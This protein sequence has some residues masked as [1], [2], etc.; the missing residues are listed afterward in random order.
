[1]AAVRRLLVVVAC[2]G[3]AGGGGTWAQVTV[4]VTVTA[5][6][7]DAIEALVQRAW[8]VSPVVL[9][10]QA[11][12][13]R[14]SWSLSPEGRL[15]E[16][17]SVT[18]SAGLGGD[19]YGQAAP[20]A[21]ISVSLDIMALAGEPETGRVQALEARL[22]EA[23]ARVRV[24]VIEAVVRLLIARAAAESAAQA[25]ETA[26]AS[27]KVAEA[28]LELGDVTA[29]AVLEARLGVSQAAVGLLRANAEA[30]VA[31]EGLAALVGVD[32]AEAGL[33]LGF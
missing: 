15:A 27:F 10:A 9:E 2:V 12:L 21:A 8:S 7:R 22:V 3:L 18:G 25:L 17:L 6:Q 26:E 11:A 30:V 33:L 14:S 31:L 13:A 24:E 19:V 29:T 32:A 23:R 28:R 20:R 5:A 16:A 1:M 4:G